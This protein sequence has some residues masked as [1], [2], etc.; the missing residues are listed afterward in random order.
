MIRSGQIK[1]LALLTGAL[2][3]TTLAGGVAAAG[4]R[5]A[6]LGGVLASARVGGRPADAPKQQQPA[7]AVEWFK[8][9]PETAKHWTLTADPADKLRFTIT[10]NAQELQGGSQ[11][12]VLALFTKPSGGY[13]TALSTMLDVFVEKRQGVTITGVNFEN[14]PE[15]G[16]KVLEAAVAERYDLIISLGSDC[17]AFLW[18]HFR[19]GAIPVVSVNAKDPVLLGHMQDYQNGSGANFAFTSLDVPIDLQVT[20]LKQLKKDLKNVA[21]MYADSNESAKRTQVRP[22]KAVADQYGITVHDVV[23]KNDKQA[24]QE[25]AEKVPQIVAEMLKTDPDG[26]NSIFWITGSTEVYREIE[27]I[28][29][30]AGKIPVLSAVPDVVQEGDNSAVLSVGVSFESNAHL[31]ALYAHDIMTG[32][33]KAGEL[34]VGVVTPPDIAINFRKARQVGL[35][36]PFSFFESASFIY[37]YEGKA[38]RKNGQTVL[39][40]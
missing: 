4:G 38:V 11:K 32:K 23:V 28:V 16:K 5:P 21:V 24:R 6:R 39:G 36:I 22:L 15:Q 34:K 12:K 7:S 20:Y 10:P 3:F 13:N 33:A 25:L 31:A 1:L 30:N 37:D 29:A 17:T 2:V 26:T 8:L 18:E 27:T 35:K 19:N 40:R 14:K 9:T